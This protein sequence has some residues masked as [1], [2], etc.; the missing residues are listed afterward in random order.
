MTES[1]ARNVGLL[2]SCSRWPNLIRSVHLVMCDKISHD[3]AIWCSRFDCCLFHSFQVVKSGQC[4]VHCFAKKSQKNI[5]IGRYV[6]R[7]DD[8]LGS[9]SFGCCP[10]FNS[11]WHLVQLQ[12]QR[13]KKN[14]E[15]LHHSI[16]Q[17]TVKQSKIKR[18]GASKPCRVKVIDL[19]SDLVKVLANTRNF[20]VSINSGPCL[21][22][23]EYEFIYITLNSV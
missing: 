23:K 17:R 15:C 1:W 18:E 21:R 22:V 11:V 2:P 3:C 19:W 9:L 13:L 7:Q 10:S 12:K 6:K 5:V 14:Y 16:Q 20:C 4:F 8:L